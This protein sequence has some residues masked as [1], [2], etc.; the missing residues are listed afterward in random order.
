M[1]EVKQAGGIFIRSGTP[2]PQTLHFESEPYVAGWRS[3]TSLDV[4]GLDRQIQ[5]AGW[6][7]FCLAGETKRTVF[8]ID[9]G[10]TLR[11]AVAQILAAMKSE[12]NSMEITQVTSGGSKRFLG[13]C[14]LTVSARPRHI[15]ESAFLSR[16][17]DPQE[18]GK[19]RL[20]AQ[21]TK[22]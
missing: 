8:G 4:Y 2:L 19:A 21:G 20:A 3:V 15:Q 9:E 13:V 16:G 10:K 7:F 5:D 6:A 1:P 11:R 18:C 17:K 22:A 12:F 14:H